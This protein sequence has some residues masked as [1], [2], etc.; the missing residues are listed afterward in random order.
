LRSLLEKLSSLLDDLD[1]AR[2]KT[3]ESTT[4]RPY[5]KHQTHIHPRTTIMPPKQQRIVVQKADARR[6]APK[7][8]F[9]SAYNTLTSPDNASVVRSVA[10]FGVCFPHPCVKEQGPVVLVR[11]MSQV[12]IQ[13]GCS[14]KWKRGF[15]GEWLTVDVLRLLLRSFQ[16]LGASSCCLR[17]LQ[18]IVS[19]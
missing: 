9:S 12:H 6:P 4:A 11:G 16:A 17:K 7:G 5:I 15:L 8:Y 10:V 2:N 13:E 14:W 1:S 18:A 3:Y 19:T